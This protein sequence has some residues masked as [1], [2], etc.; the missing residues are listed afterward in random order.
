MVRPL[1]KVPVMVMFWD[2]EKEDGFEAAAKLMFD[3]T[4]TDHLDIESIMF[5]SERLRQLLCE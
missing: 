4:I 1:P 2:E 5:L 3:E